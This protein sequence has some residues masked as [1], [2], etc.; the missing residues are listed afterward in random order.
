MNS[1]TRAV[2]AATALLAFASARAETCSIHPPA[3]A[4]DKQLAALAKVPQSTAR[5]VALDSLKQ[6]GAKHVKS[7]ELEA[8]HG[9]LIWS[10]DIGI[11]GSNLTHE[12]AVDAGNAAIVSSTTENPAQ[13][14][15]EA[16]GETKP[17]HGG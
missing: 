2:I 9:C 3:H 8:E 7:A 5:K 15:D 16:R 6:P 4:T 17:A 10:F 1:T 12:V 13:E 14:A 11:A